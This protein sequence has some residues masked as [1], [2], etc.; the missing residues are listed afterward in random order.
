MNKNIEKLVGINMGKPIIKVKH[1]ELTRAEAD[2]PHKSNCPACKESVLLMI[3][4]RKTFKLR[5]H[6]MCILCGQQ[7]EYTDIPDNQLAFLNYD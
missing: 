7:F 2:S 5:N 4:D 3:R 6:D 1:S